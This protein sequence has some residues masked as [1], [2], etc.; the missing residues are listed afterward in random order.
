MRWEIVLSFVH[1]RARCAPIGELANDSIFSCVG[2][3][4]SEAAVFVGCDMYD[5]GECY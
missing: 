1:M 4:G 3:V 2:L 5:V